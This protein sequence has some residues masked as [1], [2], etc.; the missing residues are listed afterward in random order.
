M[1]KI[2]INSVLFFSIIC[3]LIVFQVSI[4]AA[5]KTQ[6]SFSTGSLGG[7]FYPIGGGISEYLSKKH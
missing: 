3:L 5:T 4:F 1:R 7:S 2:K 6:F